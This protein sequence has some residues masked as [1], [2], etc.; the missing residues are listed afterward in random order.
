MVFIVSPQHQQQKFGRVTENFFEKNIKVWTKVTRSSHSKHATSTTVPVWALHA[1]ENA[2][3]GSTALG[4]PI[5]QLREAVPKVFPQTPGCLKPVQGTCGIKTTLVTKPARH[6]PF[7]VL[8]LAPVAQK[9]L[10]V[11]PL[12]IK[13][14][15]PD[16]AWCQCVLYYHALAQWEKKMVGFTQEGLLTMQ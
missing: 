8:A 16:H 11:K 1:P 10:W 5:L 13:A 4:F 15:V 6:L 3:L 7:S 2:R 12:G 9:Q 14:V